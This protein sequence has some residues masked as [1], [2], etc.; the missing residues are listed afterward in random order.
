MKI[1]IIGDSFGLPRLKKNTNIIEVTYEQTYPEQLRRMLKLFYEPEDIVMINSCKRFNNSFYLYKYELLETLLIQPEYIVI[2][3]GIVDCWTRSENDYICEEFKGK[4][5]WISSNE[6]VNYI[7]N[8][9]IK[10]CENIVQLKGII[11]VNISKA[12]SLQYKKHKGSFERTVEYNNK[13]SLISKKY[14]NVFLADIYNSFSKDLEKA[15]C[16][17]GIHPNEYGNRLISNEI[18]DIIVSKIRT[19]N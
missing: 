15:L 19:E 8:F 4:N 7:E 1:Q 2:Q 12:S 13:L 14:N 16:S 17:D 9:I 6:Y 5:P 3:L 10:C 11:L 18:F